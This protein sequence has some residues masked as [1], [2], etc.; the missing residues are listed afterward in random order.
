MDL[1]S[2]WMEATAQWAERKVY[3][4]AGWA[5]DPSLLLAKPYLSLTRTDGSQYASFI[6]ARHMEEQIA[7]SNP[8]IIKETWEQYK[9][10][11]ANNAG[12]EMITAI[13]Q[14]L[15]R[16]AYTTSLRNE[17]P[18]F[19]WETY[20]LNGDSFAQQV[21]AY[22]SEWDT[23]GT[24]IARPE[25]RLFRVKLNL[26]D[27]VAASFVIGENRFPDDEV[28]GPPMNAPHQIDHLGTIYVEFYPNNLNLPP[29]TGADLNLTITIRNGSVL[30]E[31]DRPKVRVIPV[32]DFIV[33]PHLFGASVEPSVV[34][35]DLVYLSS[36][37][38]FDRFDR[39]VMII[40]N[41]GLGS[42]LDGMTYSY[43]ATI[44]RR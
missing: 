32:P 19:A 41:I 36:V 29:N 20:F 34:V 26:A 35:P 6:F 22:T 16:A 4:S 9:A 31:A 11:A 33:T 8:D 1:R 15:Q 44:T 43:H 10:S 27:T 30:D 13:D 3:P 17:F 25:W 42:G 5:A 24:P 18:K 7:Q 21:L 37:Q 40:S 39:V 28:V 14:V 38:D 12:A 23:T 2:W